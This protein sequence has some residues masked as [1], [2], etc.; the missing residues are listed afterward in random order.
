M[1]KKEFLNVMEKRLSM[2]EAQEREDMLSEYA[3]HIELKMESGMSEQEAIDDFG[4]IDSL[5]A[6]ILEAYHIDPSYKEQQKKGA[7]EGIGKKASGMFNKSRQSL[8]NFMEQQKEKQE[9]RME[10]KR[11]EDLEKPPR[12]RRKEEGEDSDSRSRDVAKAAAKKTGEIIKKLLIICVKILLVLVLLPSAFMAL[13]SMFGFGVMAVL[14]LQGYPLFGAALVMLGCVM[15]FGAL[16][17]FIV[18]FIIS[19]WTERKDVEA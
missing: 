10:Q 11:K 14:L 5:I 1:N 13:S 3:Q 4:D 12:W 7:A 15:G 17:L 18:T 6:E 9:Q 8:S 19:R 2:L 16:S